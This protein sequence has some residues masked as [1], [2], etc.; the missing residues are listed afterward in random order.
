MKRIIA[1]A[2]VLY[3]ALFPAMPA[4]VGL[5]IISDLAGAALD[6]VS[7]E[8]ALNAANDVLYAVE[9]DAAQRQ[10]LREHIKRRKTSMKL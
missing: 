3:L 7:Q 2:L 10:I 6:G 4:H 1:A 8:D 5:G 9:N